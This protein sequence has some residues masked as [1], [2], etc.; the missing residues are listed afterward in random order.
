MHGLQNM[1]GPGEVDDDLQPEVQEECQTKY[2]DV[3]KV[4]I[5]EITEAVPEEAVRIFVEFK[6]LESAIK[7][8][9]HFVFTFDDWS[10]CSIFNIYLHYNNVT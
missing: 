3:N 7:G 6:R 4:L 5:F 9:L 8:I 2:G 1:V 10:S